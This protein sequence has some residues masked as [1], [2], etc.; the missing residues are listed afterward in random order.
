MTGDGN[1]TRSTKKRINAVLRI[2]AVGAAW[3]IGRRRSELE[4]DNPERKII[5]T[6]QNSD[7]V[8][9]LALNN[10]HWYEAS[11]SVDMI[12]REGERRS[13]FC[14]T[15]RRGQAYTPDQVYT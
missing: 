14:A 15:A 13:H 2:L 3:S 4:S 10:N 11:S 12:G 6:G 1:L 9:K 8:R 7:P 5:E